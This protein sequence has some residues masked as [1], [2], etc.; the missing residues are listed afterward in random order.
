[1]LNTPQRYLPGTLFLILL[2]FT[3]CSTSGSILSDADSMYPGWYSSS[4]FTSDSLVFHGFAAAISSDSA[5]AVANAN[6]QARTVLE[7]RI[8]EKLETI[9][10]ALEENGTTIASD[11][12]FIF[13]LRNAHQS[14][15]V[16]A[17][18]T[19]GEARAADDYYT[20]FSRVSISKTELRSLLESGFT[21]KEG[22]WKQLSSSPAF[23][24]EL[25]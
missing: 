16:A 19:M 10:Q 18:N 25:E 5:T 4:G 24:K 9:R 23:E 21:E 14:V 20:G 3:A 22:Y 7:S 6:M 8:A 15:E 17:D 2:V 11:A 1:M 13:T 12:D